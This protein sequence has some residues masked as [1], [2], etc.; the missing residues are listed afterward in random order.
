MKVCFSPLLILFMVKSEFGISI[1]KQCFSPL[2]ILFMVKLGRLLEDRM[3]SFSP[4]LIL[5][6]VKYVC[7]LIS[8]HRVLVPC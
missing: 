5:F 7:I 3:I 2:L 6:M 1:T 4:L 8:T